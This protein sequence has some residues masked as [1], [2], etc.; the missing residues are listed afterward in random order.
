MSFYRQNVHPA[1]LVRRSR[2][3]AFG[4]SLVIVV[5]IG[6]ALFA[7]NRSVAWKTSATL[8]ATRE[9]VGPHA[10]IAAVVCSSSGTEAFAVGAHGEVFERTS[11]LALDAAARWTR[12][13]TGTTE[14]L[15]AVALGNGPTLE[16]G[17][18]GPLEVLQAMA[19]GAHGVLVACASRATSRCRSQKAD[20]DAT[21]RAVAIDG[22]QAIAVGEHGT[23]LHVRANADAR[24]RGDHDAPLLLAER[25]EV[26][27]L[28]SDLV[29]VTL[30]CADSNAGFA[31]D[32]DIG[33]ARRVLVHGHGVGRCDDGFAVSGTHTECTWSW[34]S[35][36]PV[37]RAPRTIRGPIHLSHAKL[38]MRRD[39]QRTAALSFEPMLRATSDDRDWPLAQTPRFIAGASPK[40]ED[41]RVALLV[42][43][44]DVYLAR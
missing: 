1:T 19:V 25:A 14:D 10:P 5:A 17:W 16:G 36:T 13:E 35:T 6:G 4:V 24:R 44:G 34:S 12:L 29:A 11:E 2:R 15:L 37:D 18:L 9:D 27:G 30:R 20:V 43:D 28:T 42:A 38:W 40:I 31:C 8:H 23:I 7:A 39:E 22:G 21:L 41:G 3:S 26:P 33:D 32:A